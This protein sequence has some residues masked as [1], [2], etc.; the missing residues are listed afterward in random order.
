MRVPLDA[1]VLGEAGVLAGDDRALQVADDALVGST[2]CWLHSDA[3]AFRPAA[4]RPRCAGR[5]W[6]AGRRRPSAP[7]RSAKTSCSASSAQQQQRQQRAARAT[8]CGG[9]HGA[10][11]PCGAQ[12]LQ[13]RR[14][15]GLH[16][17]PERRRPRPPARPACPGR[18]APRR[19]A[20]RAQARKGCGGRRRTSGPPPARRAAAPAGGT[21]TAAPCRLLALALSTTSKACAGVVQAAGRAAR[22]PCSRGQRGVALPPAPAP[23]RACGWPPPPRAG[24]ASSSGPSTPAAAPPAPISS[25][26]RPASGTPALRS[27]SRT[28]PMPS[29]LSA[30]QPS[31]SKRSTL[32]ACASA[33][34][35]VSA[36]PARG[37]SNLNGTVTLQPRPPLGGEGAHRGLEAVQRAQHAAVLDGL[38]RSAARTR[39][40]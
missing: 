31:A 2:H 10:R 18:R 30:S 28:R 33:A 34:R 6:T 19:R 4:A 5:W 36:R 17:A 8:A 25:T 16:A 13:H 20:L 39:H 1:A 14:R 9:L 23:C 35:G 27:M 26:R 11:R 15:V 24:R 7:M 21:G 37:A 29:V 22:T 12:P 38:R 3:A 32:A 40:G